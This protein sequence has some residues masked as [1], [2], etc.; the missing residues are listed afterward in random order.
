VPWGRRGKG[1]EEIAFRFSNH[2]QEREG[3][4]RILEKEGKKRGVFQTPFIVRSLAII[5][6]TQI[7]KKGGRKKKKRG[8]KELLRMQIITVLTLS[9]RITTVKESYLFGQREVMKEGKRRKRKKKKKA[10]SIPC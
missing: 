2:H 3:G 8:G 4:L 7:R 9:Q 1:K 6:R 10:A 5:Q